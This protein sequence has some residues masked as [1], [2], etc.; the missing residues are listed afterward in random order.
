MEQF[1]LAIAGAARAM[2]FSQGLAITGLL[3]I[4]G[5]SSAALA[6]PCN[7]A[8]DGTYCA[9]AGVRRSDSTTLYNT[10]PRYSLGEIPAIS[11]KSRLKCA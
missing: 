10:S 4:A 1:A 11:R 7:P 3:L 9:E 6:Q 2:T 5:A 8:I